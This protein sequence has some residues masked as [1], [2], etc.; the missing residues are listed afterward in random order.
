MTWFDFARSVSAGGLTLLSLVS[1]CQSPEPDRAPAA[2]TAAPAV[3]AEAPGFLY[4]RVRTYDG[5]VYEGRLRWG[6]NEEAFWTDYFNGV[7]DDNPWA[8]YT[9][10]EQEAQQRRPVEIFGVELPL[11]WGDPEVDLGRPFMARF[12]D[13]AQIEARGDGVRGVIEDGVEFD[14]EVRVTLKSGT[15]FDLDRLSASDFDDGIRVWD[16]QRG[17]VDLGPR[18]V[19]SIE[20]LPPPRPHGVADRLHGTVRTRWGDFSGFLQWD[21]EESIG[22]DVLAGRVDGQEV[23]VRFAAI[24]SIERRAEGGARVTLRD[25]RQLVLSGSR[26]VGPDNRGVYVDDPR[27]GRVLV[28][29]DAFERVDLSPGGSPER[30]GLAY[31][32]FPPGQPLAGTVTTRDGRRIRGRLVY[33]LDESETTE[34]LDAPLEGVDYTLPFALIESVVLDGAGRAGGTA[35]VRLRSGEDLPLERAGDLG[36]DNA[37]LLVFADSQDRPEYVPWPDVARIDLDDRLAEAQPTGGR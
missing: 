16:H 5:A 26:K 17:V 10:L 22:G 34:T 30:G 35:T 29:W 28:S 6:G 15:V 1:G 27:Y 11:P 23:G 2:A 8:H 9:P 19:R 36:E 33:D 24:R 18:R 13:I 37:G 7:K 14:P 25:G 3:A 20:F 21:R 4:G 12:G 32:D 31:D